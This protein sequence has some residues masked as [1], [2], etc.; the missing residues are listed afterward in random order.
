MFVIELACCTCLIF[1]CRTGF[2]G[3]GHLCAEDLDLDGFPDVEL[4]C[5]EKECRKVRRKVT[6]EREQQFLS[7]QIVMNPDKRDSTFQ[8]DIHGRMLRRLRNINCVIDNKHVIMLVLK[9]KLN[10]AMCNTNQCLTPFSWLLKACPKGF[11]CQ[12]C[13]SHVTK[14]LSF[15]FHRITAWEYQ[16]P[17]KKI[18]TMTDWATFVMTTWMVTT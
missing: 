11:E 5:T 4:N 15:L 8:R 18:W 9:I 10:Y 14:E 6:N 13:S 7:N 12:Q 3:N 16:I 2:S 17:I 1:Q